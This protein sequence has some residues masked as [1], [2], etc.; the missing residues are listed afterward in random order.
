MVS[1]HWP[2]FMLRIVKSNDPPVSDRV[3]I[4]ERE[5][6]RPSNLRHIADTNFY[7][8]ISRSQRQFIDHWNLPTVSYYSTYDNRAGAVRK[9]TLRNHL[10]VLLKR[11]AKFDPGLLVY[12]LTPWVTF[13]DS[14]SLIT[15]TVEL[16]YLIISKSVYQIIVLLC[17]GS[18]LEKDNSGHFIS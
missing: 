2:T 14:D 9:S 10:I 18:M 3:G 12:T 13:D 6:Q 8:A 17:Q 4:L 11:E 16:V 1:V 5:I 15:R 7:M